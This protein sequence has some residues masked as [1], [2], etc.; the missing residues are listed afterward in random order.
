[1]KLHLAVLALTFIGIISI[2]INGYS[3]SLW[4]LEQKT[5]NLRS[6]FTSKRFIAESFKNT[7]GG[8]GFENLEQWQNC[9]KSMFKLESISYEQTDGNVFHAKWDGTDVL[10]ECSGEVFFVEK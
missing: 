1:M 8:K 4:R 3:L 9:C 10:S 6:V 2:S 7:C 5:R